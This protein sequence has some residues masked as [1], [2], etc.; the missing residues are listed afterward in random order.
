MTKGQ[1]NIKVYLDAVKEARL[2]GQDDQQ[3]AAAG[4]AAIKDAGVSLPKEG[5]YK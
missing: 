4:E 5:Q 2:E 1:P 3:A